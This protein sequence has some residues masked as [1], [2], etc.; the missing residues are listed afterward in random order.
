MACPPAYEEGGACRRQAFTDHAALFWLDAGAPR[1]A[2][3]LARLNL[4]VRRT[5]RAEALVPRA[6]EAYRSSME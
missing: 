1:R 5:P 4:S 3:D 2:L 6:A